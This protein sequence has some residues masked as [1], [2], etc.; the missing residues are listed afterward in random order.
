MHFQLRHEETL[1]IESTQLKRW[2]ITEIPINAW[3]K[4]S[5]GFS[6]NKKKKQIQTQAHHYDCNFILL[7]T[8]RC[9]SG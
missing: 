2:T 6:Q 7:P 8:K 4:S 5:D 1:D 3:L 9:K